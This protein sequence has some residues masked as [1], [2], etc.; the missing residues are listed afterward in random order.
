[1]ICHWCGAALRFEP[2][3]GWVHP[4][5]SLYIRK[6]GKCG[7]RTDDPADSRCLGC[8]RRGLVDDHCALPVQLS[9][10]GTPA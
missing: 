4:G 7:W 10:A 8:G 5:G 3:R 9:A 2:T 1:M 6:C